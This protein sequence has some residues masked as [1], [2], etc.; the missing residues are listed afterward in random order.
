MKEKIKSFFEKNNWKYIDNGS[1]LKLDV[2][3]DGLTWYT[4]FKVDQAESF[5]CFSVLPT[6]ISAKRIPTVMKLLNFI[7]TRIWF[8]S[9]ELIT[10]GPELG[11]VRLRASAFVPNGCD[12]NTA[13]EIIANVVTFGSAVMNLYAGDIIKANYSESDDVETLLSE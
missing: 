11:Q 4:F 9:F 10:D 5:A 12:E 2:D 7:N 13:E 3:G 8:G 6:R 1:V